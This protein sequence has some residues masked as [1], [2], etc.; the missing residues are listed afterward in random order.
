[1]LDD[2]HLFLKHN[3]GMHV[4]FKILFLF[5]VLHVTSSTSLLNLTINE[6]EIINFFSTF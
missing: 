6:D 4:Q 5:L 1:M 2:T 3:S